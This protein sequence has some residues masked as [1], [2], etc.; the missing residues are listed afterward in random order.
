MATHSGILAWR[1]T[2][3]EEPGGLQFMEFHR[4]GHDQSDLAHCFARPRET[5]QAPA[6]KNCV[7]TPEN[8]MKSFITVVQRWVLTR[9]VNEWGLKVK[10]KC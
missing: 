6:L 5:H 2:W 8:L 3:T 1:I 9:L 7:S 10:V 4:V